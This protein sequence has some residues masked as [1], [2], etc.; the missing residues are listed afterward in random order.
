MCASGGMGH[1]VSS[2]SDS[3]CAADGCHKRRGSVGG[4]TAT[5]KH[6]TLGSSSGSDVAVHEG[7]DL[8]DTGQYNEH[9]NASSLK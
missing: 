2:D 3:D 6:K 8:S 1:C 5:S 7:A 4:R 9:S